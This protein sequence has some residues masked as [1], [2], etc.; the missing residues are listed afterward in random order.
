MRDASES[1]LRQAR[2]RAG[3][4][5]ARAA[6]E[7]GISPGWY[8]LVEREPTFLTPRLAARVAQALGCAASDLLP[9][10]GGER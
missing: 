2:R 5:Q 4:T 10:K 7:I 9:A 6:A 8:A 1:P 3:K